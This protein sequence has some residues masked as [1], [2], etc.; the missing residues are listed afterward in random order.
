MPP[1]KYGP[2]NLRAEPPKAVPAPVPEPVQATIAKPVEPAPVV[3]A[4]KPLPEPIHPFRDVCETAYLPPHERNFGRLPPKQDKNRDAAYRMHAPIQNADTVEAVFKRSMETPFVTLSQ[5]ELLSLSVDCCQKMRESVTPKR[6]PPKDVKIQVIDDDD[7]ETDLPFSKLLVSVTAQDIVSSVDAIIV[8]DPY[9]LYLTSLKQG[10]IPKVLTITEESHALRSIFMK[11]NGTADVEAI[12]DPGSQIIAMSEA[13]CLDLGLIYNPTIRLNMESGNGQINPSLGL[14]CNVPCK[15]RDMT[16]VLQIHV[17]R[18]P[19][20][21]ILLG[22]P[23]DV[24]T[25]STVK[26]YQNEHQTITMRDP[27]TGNQATVATVSRGPPRYG[28]YDR[29]RDNPN[30]ASKSEEDFQRSRD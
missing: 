22:C 17:V 4:P 12:L 6:S 10:E 24:L 20:Y 3:T 21:D 14:A 13:V 7:S 2:P 8:P 9:E 30:K 1:R 18:S 28:S 19:A 27:N 11:V 16:L 26:N 23:F 25:E 29:T 5:S 15:I